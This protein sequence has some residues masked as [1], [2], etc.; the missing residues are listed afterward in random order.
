MAVRRTRAM[1]EL[2]EAV[3]LPEFRDLTRWTNFLTILLGLCFAGG[4]VFIWSNWT[5]YQAMDRSLSFAD[6]RELNHRQ[7]VTRWIFSGATLLVAPFFARW[8]VLAHRNL[9]AMGAKD[10]KFVPGWVVG[11]YFVPIFNIWAPFLA[12]LEL[13]RASRAP[14]DWKKAKASLLAPLWWLLWLSVLPARWVARTHLQDATSNQELKEGL[15]Y[16]MLATAFLAL[17]A[18]I[19]AILFRRIAKLQARALPAPSV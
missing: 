19:A 5:M 7:I 17:A 13:C 12:M 15:P 18:L 11:F 16:A 9:I 6:V 14:Q 2:E 3:E 8:L 10:L 1:Q 4:L